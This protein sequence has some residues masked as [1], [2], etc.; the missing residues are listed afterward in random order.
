[1]PGKPLLGEHAHVRAVRGDRRD[2]LELARPDAEGVALRRLEPG[3]LGAEPVGVV[4][5]ER[6]R[7]ARKS[8][9]PDT[10]TAPATS[11]AATSASDEREQRLASASTS[12]AP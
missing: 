9:D 7:S 11:A 1:M 5:L 8:P 12:A 6:A 2:E 10:E 4:A 3:G